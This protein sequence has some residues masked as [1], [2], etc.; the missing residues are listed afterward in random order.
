MLKALLTK[1]LSGQT[2]ELAVPILANE[3][4]GFVCVLGC[5]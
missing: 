3:G 5:S 1:W 4:S 2:L